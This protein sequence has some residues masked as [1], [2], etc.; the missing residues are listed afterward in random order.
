MLQSGDFLG[1]FYPGEEVG[2]AGV[3]RVAL[4]VTLVLP[5]LLFKPAAQKE[6]GG[7]WLV[8]VL[9]RGQV[10]TMGSHIWGARGATGYTWRM[11]FYWI[12]HRGTLRNIV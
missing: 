6:K 4:G 8:K 5:S 9:S 7:Q 12:S 3:S 2:Q 10:E 1:A 11:E